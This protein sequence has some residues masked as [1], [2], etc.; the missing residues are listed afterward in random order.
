MPSQ[1]ENRDPNEVIILVRNHGPLRVY[2]P[3]RMID[4]N[5]NEYAIPE[6]EWFSLCRCGKSETKP[7]CDS[8][9]KTCDFHAPSDATAP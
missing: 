9:H 4:V 7:F 6:G 1:I 5:G 3:A 8:A 2:G